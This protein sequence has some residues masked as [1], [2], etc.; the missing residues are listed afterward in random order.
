MRNV[1]GVKRELRPPCPVPHQRVRVLN[2]S[3]CYVGPSTRVSARKSR[4]SLQ[5]NTPCVSGPNCNRSTL[6]QQTALRTNF[7]DR[8][9]DNMVSLRQAGNRCQ[10]LASGCA[11]GHGTIHVHVEL[12]SSSDVSEK[13]NALSCTASVSINQCK[14]QM[15]S[16]I[17]VE[18]DGRSIPARRMHRGN[19]AEKVVQWTR[20]F[21]RTTLVPSGV[22]VR[23]SSAST[24]WCARIPEKGR[25][26]LQD[27]IPSGFRHSRGLGGT[28]SKITVYVA[29][30][31]GRLCAMQVEAL[32]SIVSSRGTYAIIA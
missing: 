17:E 31:V 23:D 13:L 24:A 20:G 22:Q 12:Q 4:H 19:I 2:N 8:Q 9:T 14:L 11:S 10:Q 29:L 7:G 1:P 27:I 30:G 32:S 21:K 6:K 26:I 28:E 15:L 18:R 16:T 25:V 5:T 3:A